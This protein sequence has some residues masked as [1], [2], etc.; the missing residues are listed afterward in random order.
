MINW[1]KRYF[2]PVLI[3]MVLGL[4]LGTV[5]GCA[6]LGFP[7]LEPQEVNQAPVEKVTPPTVVSTEDKAILAVYEHLLSQAGSAEAKK[8]LAD[9]YTA[10]DNWEAETELFKDGS[11]IWYVQVDMTDTE[12]WEWRP[13]WIKASWFILPDG[14]VIPS[15]RLQANALRIEADLQELSPKPDEPATE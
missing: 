15:N 14:R 4:L 10:S 13:Y 6:E 12:T 2:K 9:F 8:Y 1:R 3:I 11:S 5:S 7:P